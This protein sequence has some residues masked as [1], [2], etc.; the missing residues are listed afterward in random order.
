MWT[1]RGLPS[2]LLL[3]Q[4]VFPPGSQHGQLHHHEE[5][6]GA[7]DTVSLK[8]SDE[9]TRAGDQVEAGLCAQNGPI[10]RL[11]PQGDTRDQ[12][13]QKQEWRQEPQEFVARELKGEATVTKRIQ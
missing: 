9:P 6:C 4:R 7:D 13:R 10:K 12:S 5:V 11:A 1:S 3:T 2:H 8:R